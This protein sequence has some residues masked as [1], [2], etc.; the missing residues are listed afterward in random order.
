MTTD[1]FRHALHSGLGR[2]LLYARSQ[3]VSTFHDILLDASLYCRTV[4][5]QWEGTRAPFVLEILATLPD[6]APYYD[7]VLRALPDD[8][9]TW[10]SAHRFFI[11][12]CLAEDGYP[13][14]RDAMY[15]AYQ[16]G[17]SFGDHIATNFVDVDGA[18]GLRYAAMRLGEVAN[19]NVGLLLS[20]ATDR[21]G[22]TDAW[23]ILRGDPRA[24]P[25]VKRL[26]AYEARL[27]EP[28][29]RRRRKRFE[30]PEPP[31]PEDRARLLAQLKQ[32]TDPDSLHNLQR[33]LRR[34]IQHH[35]DPPNDVHTLH[36]LHER[37]SCSQCREFIVRDLLDRNALP[38]EMRAEC[39]YDANPEIRELMNQA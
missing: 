18:D 26:E 8:P 35:P 5:P 3:D 23:N 33:K 34:L 31:G 21:F 37:G 32:D 7:A 15:S 6:P 14:A 20:H 16:P 11:A 2:A 25:Y 24:E 22:E 13:G 4:D 30:L 38:Q 19:G 27:A 9:D 29:K 39:A 17:P 28:V 10:H 1:Q 36:L 12:G